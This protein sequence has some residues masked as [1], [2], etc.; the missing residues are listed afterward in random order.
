MKHTAAAALFAVLFAAAA[1]AAPVER[2]HE[3]Q[4]P[5]ISDP[6]IVKEGSAFQ[7]KLK[8]D[9]GG[10]ADAA[11]LDSLDDPTVQYELKLT[12]APAENGLTVYN[13]TAPAKTPPALYNLAVRLSEYSWDFQP[14]AVKVVKEF[15]NE[16]DFIQL[17]DIHFNH[18]F[19]KN[20][21][22]NR[23]RRM[24]LQKI[25]KESAEFVVFSGDLGLDPETYD[26]DYVYGYEEFLQWM[27]LPMYMVPGN[28]EMYYTEMDGRKVD[29][30]EY[31]KAI[32]GPT[33]NSFDYGKLHVVGINT[34]D[35]PRQWRERRSKDAMFFGT[36]I[37]AMISAEQWDWLKADLESAKAR[38]QG[39][40]AY[41]HIPIET[42]MGG[43]KVGLASPY[44]V[45]G[46]TTKTFT[47]LLNAN[48]VP[49]I[50][51]GH[52]HYNEE[53]K[54]GELNEVLTMST[55]IGGGSSS[56]WGYRIIHV[57][58][59]KVTGWKMREL[60]LADLNKPPAKPAPKK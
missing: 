57:K 54:F 47:E 4:R 3:I 60:T 34:F 31:W 58:D 29:G 43:K 50:F 2:I 10:K 53:K 38:G 12:P 36:I 16:F 55:G 15:K 8:L 9:E 25:S 18:T 39:I 27:R 45:P 33:Y 40:V 19:L 56:K 37:N 23:M 30:L 26:W 13:A 5:L 17:T 11:F 35:W 7:I 48:N 24:F 44:K 20:V 42:L 49:Y 1:M 21:D 6:A 28:H 52:M 59:G 41:S 51:I 14:H 46:P 22:M 32:Y